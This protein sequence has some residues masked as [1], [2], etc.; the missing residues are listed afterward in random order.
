MASGSSASGCG[1]V[2]VSLSGRRGRER[3]Y[4]TES[5]RAKRDH[6][7][8]YHARNTQLDVHEGQSSL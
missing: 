3:A 7:R 5:P 6:R 8:Q 1:G 2:P 4:A